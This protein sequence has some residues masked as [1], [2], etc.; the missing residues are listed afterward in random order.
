M[1]QCEF[2]VSMSHSFALFSSMPRGL[3][4]REGGRSDKFDPTVLAVTSGRVL[5]TPFIPDGR[6]LQ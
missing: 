1:C 6:G 2:F 5:T 3:S 4:N